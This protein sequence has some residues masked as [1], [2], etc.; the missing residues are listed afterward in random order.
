MGLGHLHS[1]NVWRF[2]VLLTGGL[3]Q[4]SAEKWSAGRLYTSKQK[5]GALTRGN[6]HQY[7]MV[8]IGYKGS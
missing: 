2:F 6:G 4:W 1:H 5:T 8:V 3:P 7:V